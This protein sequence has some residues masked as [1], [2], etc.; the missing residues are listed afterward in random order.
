MSPRA[1]SGLA[2]TGFERVYDYVAGKADWSSTGLPLEGQTGATRAPAPTCAR[3]FPPAA[4]TTACK[5]L[6]SSSRRAAGT[7]ASSSTRPASSSAGWGVARSEAERTSRRRRRRRRG[8][9]RSGR[10]LASPTSSSEIRRQNL[11]NL[12]VTTSDG[13]L[14]GLLMRTDAEQAVERPGRH[15]DRATAIPHCHAGVAFIAVTPAFRP[16]GVSIG[17]A[18]GRDRPTRGP[19]CSRALGEL[20]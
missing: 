16:R 13:R 1:A 7:P 3:T 2:S 19:A 5:P 20:S 14:M 18:A 9:A 4:S 12:R 6:A 8:R 10:A 17:V 11:T 15:S